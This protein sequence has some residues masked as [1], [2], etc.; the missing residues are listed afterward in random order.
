MNYRSNWIKHKKNKERV[1]INYWLKSWIR[2]RHSRSSIFAK[3]KRRLCKLNKK[4]WPTY[5]S[6]RSWKEYESS[7]IY[8]IKER[9]GEGILHQ[10]E[11]N[12]W[13]D[14]N[15]QEVRGWRWEERVAYFNRIENTLGD[16]A[17]TQ[18][19]QLMNGFGTVFEKTSIL[20]EI[21]QQQKRQKE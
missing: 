12:Y 1:S 2:R 14:E 13:A 6:D 5:D 8:Q 18:F 15:H 10:G 19:G 16:V 4:A 21:E 7:H 20:N 9:A 3:E 11:T 17:N